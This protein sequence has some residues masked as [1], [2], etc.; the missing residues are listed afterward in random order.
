ML[1]LVKLQAA[2]NSTK[3]DTWFVVIITPFS[4]ILQGEIYN[5]GLDWIKDGEELVK[6]TY[7]DWNETKVTR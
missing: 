3:I 2:C 4:Q 7:V 1:L 5:A 6:H